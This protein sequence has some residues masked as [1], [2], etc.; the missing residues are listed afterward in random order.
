MHSIQLI[1]SFSTKKQYKSDF[2]D[3]F[4]FEFKFINVKRKKKS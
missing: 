1:S 2:D 4:Q 3:E